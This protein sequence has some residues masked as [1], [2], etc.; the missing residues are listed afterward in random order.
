MKR[1][2]LLKDHG[3]MF[4][5]MH[6]LGE[7][8]FHPHNLIVCEAVTANTILIWGAVLSADVSTVGEMAGRLPALCQTSALARLAS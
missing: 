6:R 7:W 4:D 2:C 8:M 3:E 5:D 1:F